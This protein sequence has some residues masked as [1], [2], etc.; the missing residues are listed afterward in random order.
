MAGLIAALL[1]ASPPNQ[2]V[3]ANGV[4]LQYVDWGGSSHRDVIL[5]LPGLGDDVHRFDPFAPRFVD[6]F[7]VI[8]FSRRGQGDS[9]V[10]R[11]DYGT[12]TLVE[13]VRAF[14]DAMRI[15]RVNLI[16]HSIAGVEMTRFAAKYPARVRHIVYLDA[17]YDMGAAMDAAVRAKLIEPD[18]R[19]GAFPL[20]R[21]D[22]GAKATRLDFKSIKAPSLAFFVINKPVGEGKWY[23]AFELGYKGEQIAVFKRDMKRGQVV[24]F[25]DT[26][27]FF[28]NDPNK[29]DD[30]VGTIR[31]FLSKP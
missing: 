20:D 27:H 12:D 14:L 19:A 17:A 22:A 28:F 5:L 11:D 25:R 8:G 24:E 10:P 15:D 7:H 1:L 21:I 9:E 16:G 18:A 23:T 30:V 6:R 4:R 29:V 3:K 31:G 2:F 26:D 13:D